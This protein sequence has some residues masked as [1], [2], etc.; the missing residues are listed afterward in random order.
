MKTVKQHINQ[1][2][3][4]LLVS[5][6][7]LASIGSASAEVYVFWSFQTTESGTGGAQTLDVTSQ[8][9]G[10]FGSP[11]I[12]QFADTGG[13]TIGGGTGGAT[14]IDFEG[15]TWTGSNGS[16]LPGHSISW[17]A[18]GN[19]L[20][21]GSGFTLSNLDLTGLS[22]LNMRFD[23]RSATAGGGTPPTTFASVEYQVDGGGWIS[24]GVNSSWA[25]GTTFV[26]VTLDFSSLSAINGLENVDF[27]F[28]FAS[29]SKTGSTNHAIR[30]DNLEVSAIPEPSTLVL[31]GMFGLATLALRRRIGK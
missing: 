3:R 1:R 2:I 5:A 11:T 16:S 19:T 8:S 14:Y 13:A 18:T 24:T 27:R 26:P 6:A 9:P 28:V 25:T 20:F 7:F 10:A 15:T 31:I 17:D 12:T 4:A 21:T 23:I 22:D 29:G 30:L